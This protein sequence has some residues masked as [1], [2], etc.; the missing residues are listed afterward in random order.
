M[1]NKKNGIAILGLGLLLVIACT[2]PSV[3]TVLEDYYLQSKTKSYEIEE[4]SLHSKEVDLTEKLAGFQQVLFENIVVQQS[5][6]EAAKDYSSYSKDAQEAVNEF[7]S[8]LHKKMEA[9]FQAFSTTSMVIADADM[10]KVYSLWKCYAIDEKGYEYLF[11]IDETSEKILAFE[12]HVDIALMKI[13]DYYEM[14][15]N[16]AEYYGYAGG[17]LMENAIGLVN[18]EKSETAICFYNETVDEELVLMFYKNGNTL[19]FNMYPGEITVSNTMF[20]GD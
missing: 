17:T 2:V 13:E 10:E 12:L 19:S 15:E 18:E 16:M 4:I 8:Y 3:V 14:A 7:Y 9:K 20:D 6:T 1:K 11:W 5:M